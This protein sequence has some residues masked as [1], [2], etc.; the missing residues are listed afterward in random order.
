M[1]WKWSKFENLSAEELYDII[2]LRERVFVVEQK[3]AY[4]DADGYDKDAWHLCGWSDDKKTAL[5]AY[6]RVL[7]SSSRY[8]EPSIGR[9]ATAPE[10]RGKGLGRQ[11]MVESLKRIQQELGDISVR[12]SAQAYLE[13]FY[14]NLGFTKVGESYLEDGIEHI[15]MFLDHS[16]K[17]VRTLEIGG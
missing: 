8:A 1:N 15:E 11:A 3:C 4:Q 9:V 5:L 7:P 14:S 17:K 10:A 13:K 12:I 6:I 16:T 2:A